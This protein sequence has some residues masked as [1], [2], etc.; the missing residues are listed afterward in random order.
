[1]KAEGRPQLHEARGE[2]RRQQQAE[3]KSPFLKKNEEVSHII[4]DA[5]PEE[6]TGNST[7]HSLLSEGQ[8][9]PLDRAAAR[10]SVRKEPGMPP[11]QGGG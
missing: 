1:M 2:E 9:V 8:T 5:S 4:G 3:N 10:G 7:C 11:P 6:D